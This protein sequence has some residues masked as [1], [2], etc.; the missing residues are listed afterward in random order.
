MVSDRPTILIVEDDKN[1][2]AGIAENLSA[3]GYATEIVRTGTEAPDRIQSLNPD[4]VVLDVML[5]GKDGLQICRE[6]RAAG[7]EV[8]ILFL[9]ARGH[10]E[11][12][13]RGLSAGG[14]DYL[15]KP[16]HLQEFL[17]RVK[18]VLKR[19]RGADAE[20]EPVLTFGENE[21]SFRTFTARA[22]NGT[23]HELTEKEVAILRALSRRP[24]E[25]VSREDLLEQAWGTEVFPSTR[26]IDNFILRLRKRFEVD[27]Q[28]P[29]YFLTIRGV[30]YRFV[31]E[32]VYP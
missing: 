20:A 13:V 8:P 31:P 10:L 19:W 16:F 25:V 29:R 9:T 15:T 3:E 4:L 30:G 28:N 21:I 26:T 6:V 24:D 11:D 14:D 17:L 2:A 5:P 23:E 7:I 18:A 32:G 22:W 12:R 27:P 1:L